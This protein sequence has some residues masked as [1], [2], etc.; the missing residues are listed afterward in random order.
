MARVWLIRH[1]ESESN[2]G[3][4]GGEP[5]A[6]ALTELGRRQAAEIAKSLAEPPRLIVTS[7]F[8][9]ARQTAEPTIER[10]PGAECEEWPVQEFTFLGELHGQVTTTATRKPYTEA[11]WSRADPHHAVNGAESFAALFDRTQEFLARLGERE[12]GPIAVFTHGLFI[13][14]VM[15]SLLTGTTT[16]DSGAM[17]RFRTFADTYLVPNGNITELRYT[18]GK[19]IPRMVVP[20]AS[21]FADR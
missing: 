19:R 1:G 18:P 14:A 4:P 20:L 21:R 17:R 5:G 11:Y 9:R 10:F 15:W 13:R 7:P 2:A 3:L 8:L 6:S 16:P 12:P